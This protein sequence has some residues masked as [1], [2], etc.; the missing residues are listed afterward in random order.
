MPHK[1]KRAGKHSGKWFGQVRHQGQK[2]RSPLLGTKA[3]AADWEAGKRRELESPA[4]TAATRRSGDSTDMVSLLE[5]CNKYLDF[6]VRYVPKTYS[7]KKMI[8][9]RLLA[10]EGLD[11]L[12]PA[13]SFTPDMALGHLDGQFKERGGN[14]ANKERKNLAAAYAWGVKF[15]GLPKDNPF[16]AVPSYPEHRVK[17]HVPTEEEFWKV[18]DV[19]QGQDRTLLLAFLHTAARRGELFRL[20]W[21]DVDFEDGSVRLLTRKRKDGSMEEDWIPMTWDLAWELAEHQDRTGRRQ[22]GLVFTHQDGRH[23][24]EAFKEDRKFL[25]TLC[26]LAEVRYF[27]RHSIRHLTASLLAKMGV[28][29]VVIQGV[30]RHKRLSTTERYVKMMDHM[31]PHL[32]LLEGGL[33]RKA[34]Q[35]AQHGALKKAATA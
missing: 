24:G 32:R 30:L 9:A 16:M 5:W 1:H 21:E 15:K 19:A 26:E 25:P 31:R 4:P 29:T 35:G 14:A 18:V 27:D 3:E 7:E 8:L 2:L 22:E 10:M 20:R 12:M 6:C 34:Q 23:K 17:R 11:V 28:P 13:A 33:G